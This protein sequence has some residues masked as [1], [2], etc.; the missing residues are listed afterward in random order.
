[1][2]QTLQILQMLLFA[3]PVLVLAGM[4]VYILVRPLCV[5]HRG[6]FLAAFLPLLL[7]NPLA[8][9]TNQLVEGGSLT[10]DW[11]FWLILTADLVLAAVILWIYRRGWLVFGGDGEQAGRQLVAYFEGQG[12]VVAVHRDQKRA[13]LGRQL[14]AQVIQVSG[15]GQREKILVLTRA[16]EV[17]LQAESTAGACLVRCAL[18]DLLQAEGITDIKHRA[19]GVLYI[20]IALVI[21]FLGWTFF[22]EPRLILLE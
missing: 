13:L 11:R 19:V 18:P 4:G 5:I 22:F 10:S 16:G 21:A 20:V 12:M 17:R 7:A 9:A 1:M 15:L 2:L 6:W 3:I 14:E 8:V